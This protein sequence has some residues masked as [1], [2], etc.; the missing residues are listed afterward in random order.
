M[1]TPCDKTA[2]SI[3]KLIDAGAEI[4]GKNKLSSFAA[5]EAPTESVDYQAPFNPRG[6]GYQY[7]AGSSSGSAAAVASYDWLDFAIGTDSEFSNVDP[8][9]PVLPDTF[10]DRKWAQTSPFQWMFFSTP[11]TWPT[12]L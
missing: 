12:F 6:D 8:R 9:K 4:V 5:R 2:K 7:P 3:Q 1:S 11:N 10:S